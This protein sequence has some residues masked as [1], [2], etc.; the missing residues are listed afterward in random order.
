MASPKQLRRWVEILRL[1]GNGFLNSEI[2]DDIASKF[3]VSRRTVQRDLRNRLMWQPLVTEIVNSA[4]KIFNR[5]DQLY[6]KAC[7][8]YLSVGG[9]LNPDDKTP[10]NLSRQEI[11]TQGKIL[12]LMRR[13]NRDFFVFLFRSGVIE[14]APILSAEQE[15]EFNFDWDKFDEKEKETVLKGFRKLLENRSEEKP[16]SLH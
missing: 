8:L 9:V 15:D 1:E 7:F 14:E 3:G 2:V 12:N 16:L 6:R 11:E 10:R 13:I 5:H 4:Y